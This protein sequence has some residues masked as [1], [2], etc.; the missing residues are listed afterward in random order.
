MSTPSRPSPE[1]SLIAL[2]AIAR[3]VIAQDRGRACALLGACVD[4]RK[5]LMIEDAGPRLASPSELENAFVAAKSHNLHARLIAVDSPKNSKKRN[6]G[7]TTRKLKLWNANQPR[8][9]L[10]GFLIQDG[11]IMKS[12]VDKC[13]ALASHWANVLQYNCNGPTV[14]GRASLRAFASPAGPP[15]LPPAHS[16]NAWA[17]EIQCSRP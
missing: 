12:E 7:V 15:A 11:Q 2:S 9:I 8:A 14:P 10:S 16:N 3:I 6:S 1:H 17:R 4:A 13:N 5:V